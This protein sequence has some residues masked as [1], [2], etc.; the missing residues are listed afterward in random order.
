MPELGCYHCAQREINHIC[1][2]DGQIPKPP[3]PKPGDPP[4]PKVPHRAKPADAPKGPPATHPSQY[5]HLRSLTDCCAQGDGSRHT[6]TFHRPSKDSDPNFLPTP[7]T[8]TPMAS[9]QRRPYKEN[10][11]TC[12]LADHILNSFDKNKRLAL[13]EEAKAIRR[14]YEKKNLTGM[15][16]EDA[17]NAL[18]ISGHA[19]A[20]ARGKELAMAI[21]NPEKDEHWLLRIS[22][23]TEGHAFGILREHFELIVSE[24]PVERGQTS[25]SYQI[26]PRGGRKCS[27]KQMT[28]RKRIRYS[29][30]GRG[31]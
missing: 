2:M 30:R 26:P 13:I 9:G 11:K 17:L 16:T 14:A 5:G 24:P 6:A 15:R 4:P 31:I 23:A 21:T 18:D 8:L 1:K 10:C 29:S 25:Y 27:R 12:N 19:F 20:V 7:D 3:P 22:F 28:Y